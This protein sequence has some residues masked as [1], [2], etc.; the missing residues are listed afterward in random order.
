MLDWQDV[1][2]TLGRSLTDAERV[3]ADMWIGDTLMLIEARLGDPDG[4]N[5]KAVSFVVREAVA[6]R[7]KSPDNERQVSVTVDDATV[8]R[9]F[10]SSSGQIEILPE[11]WEL[12]AASTARPSRE[13]FSVTPA[14][15]PGHAW[16]P[17]TA[18]WWTT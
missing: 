12:L 17:K 10:A 2:R 8:A 7:I 3:Q 16:R 9:T 18:G 13:A 6:R 11:W 4:L 14:Y 5:Q 15:R 1:Q